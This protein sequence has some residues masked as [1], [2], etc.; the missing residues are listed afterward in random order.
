MN[1]VIWH[2]QTKIKVPELFKCGWLKRVERLG[3]AEIAIAE[4]GLDNL[5]DLSYIASQT[6]QCEGF[7]RTVR[8]IRLGAK[9]NE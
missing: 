4:D 7:S 6:S 9:E 5:G 3:A 2:S 1:S 8:E